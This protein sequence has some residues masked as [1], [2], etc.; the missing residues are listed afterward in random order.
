MFTTETG[1]PRNG[2]TI[3]RQFQRRL[4]ASGLRRRTIHEPLRHGAATLLVAQGVPMFEVSALLGHS[5][6]SLTSDLYASVAPATRRG[7]AD[8]MDAVFGA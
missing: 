7:V 4:S 2:E 3:L 5:Q 8:T 6:M 1:Q